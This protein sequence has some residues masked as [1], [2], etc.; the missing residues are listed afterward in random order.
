MIYYV[1]CLKNQRPG[2]Y[3]STVGWFVTVTVPNTD[4]LTFDFF[5]LDLFPITTLTQQ[6]IMEKILNEQEAEAYLQSFQET[7]SPSIIDEPT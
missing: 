3:N 4:F 6:A 2:R 5:G 1:K 7:T